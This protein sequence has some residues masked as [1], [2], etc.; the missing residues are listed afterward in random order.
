MPPGPNVE[1]RLRLCQLAVRDFIISCQQA[2]DTE[3]NNDS[4]SGDSN[5][6]LLFNS[7]MKECDEVIID[8]AEMSA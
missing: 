8:D 2:T 1:P 4:V 7:A 5:F 6:L 3:S